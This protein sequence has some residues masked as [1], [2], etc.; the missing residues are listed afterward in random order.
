[1][2]LESGISIIHALQI[3]SGALPNIHFKRGVLQAAQEVEKGVPLAVPI[4][5]NEDFPLIIS[6]V[7]ATG[8]NTGNLDKVLADIAVYYQTEVDN[9]TDNLTKLMEPI[10][11]LIVGGV[12][13]F[14]ALVVYMPIYGLA[15]FV[16]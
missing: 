2:L 9:L 1:M 6:R 5:Q 12:V 10:I 14:L 3:V 16:A 4:S 13:A 8:E 11:L 7:I 15:N